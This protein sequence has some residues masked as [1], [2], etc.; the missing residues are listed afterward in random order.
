MG[1]FQ[2]IKEARAFKTHDHISISGSGVASTT[3][4]H[5]ANSPKA[6]KAAKAI[7]E[8]MATKEC[9]A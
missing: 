5:Y 9:K 6:K 7:S 1:I 4:A 3:S 8:M 2:L